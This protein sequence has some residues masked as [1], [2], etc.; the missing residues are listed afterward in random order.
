MV[1]FFELFSVFYL[2]SY[3]QVSLDFNCEKTE[4]DPKIFDQVLSMTGQRENIFVVIW[5]LEVVQS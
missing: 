3:K 4:N 5:Y 2:R 1:V